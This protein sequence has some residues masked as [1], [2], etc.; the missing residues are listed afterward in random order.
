VRITVTERGSGFIHQAKCIAAI[1]VI[2]L[3]MMD[4]TSIE[5]FKR[6]KKA[7]P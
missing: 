2:F 7:I 6:Q 1:K 3:V 4:A 5:A